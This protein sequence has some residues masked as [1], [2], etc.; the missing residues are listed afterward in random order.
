[1]LMPLLY[2]LKGLYAGAVYGN[3]GDTVPT[4]PAPIHALGRG[5]TRRCARA[6]LLTNKAGV[7]P[8]D[9]DSTK[10]LQAAGIW[11]VFLAVR[12]LR[13]EP[14]RFVLSDGQFQPVRVGNLICARPPPT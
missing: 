8:G 5:D 4:R 10:S 14:A 11:P 3:S 7:G 13:S 1:M 2:S 6:Q 12:F 9:P